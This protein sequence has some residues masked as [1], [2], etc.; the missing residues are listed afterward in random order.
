M[1]MSASEASR[2]QSEASSAASS[3]ST[4]FLVVLA[5]LLWGGLPVAGKLVVAD[6]P[7][8]TVGA[9]R[10]GIASLTFLLIFRHHLPSFR[11]LQWPELSIL[12]AVGI[13]GT[14]LTHGLFFVG[15]TLAPSS[16]GALLSPTVTAVATLLIAAGF[17][18]EHMSRTRIAGIVLS[19]SGL[20]L[21]VQPQGIVTPGLA[22]VLVG[23][24]LFVSTGVAFGAFTVSSKIAISKLGPQ[25]TVALGTTFGW[26]FLIVPAIGERPWHAIAHA[27]SATWASLIYLAVPGTLVT[28]YCWNLAISRLGAVRTSVFINLVPVFGVTFSWL[29]LGEQLEFAHVLGTV[30]AVAGV[31]MC[32]EGRIVMSV[33]GRLAKRGRSSS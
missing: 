17:A 24:L 14:A 1:N 9:M 30:L 4:Y 15:L 20:C 22:N 33:A 27:S 25:T 29:L 32:Q 12:I 21:V 18:R 13:T 6:F 2:P 5:C 26:L 19:T 31:W 11:S 8:M 10:Y 23:D 16:H 7:P 3:A 28:F